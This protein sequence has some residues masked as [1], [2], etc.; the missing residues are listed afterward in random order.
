LSAKS[1]FW[2]KLK[3]LL[4]SSNCPNQLNVNRQYPIRAHCSIVTVIRPEDTRCQLSW[5]R[6]RRTP[7]TSI[8]LLWTRDSFHS[9]S[10]SSGEWHDYALRSQPAWRSITAFS[11]KLRVPKVAY[12]CFSMGQITVTIEQWALVDDENGDT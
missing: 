4:I 11:S 5:K 12:C 1:W 10:S 6:C 9:C 7:Y 2:T 3:E 8:P